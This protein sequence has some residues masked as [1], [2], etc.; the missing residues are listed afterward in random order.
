MAERVGFEPTRLA[1]TYFRGTHFRPLRH[2]SRCC[3]DD[4]RNGG[5]SGIRTRDTCVYTLSRRAPSTTRTPL[6]DFHDYDGCV[7]GKLN[8]LA[9][10]EGFEPSR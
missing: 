6:Q 10:G 9:E 8:R 1:S 5:E 3:I 4:E 2:L 7:W